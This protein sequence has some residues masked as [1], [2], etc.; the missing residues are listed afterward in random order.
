[1]N[2][3]LWGGTSHGAKS[4]GGGVEVPV[5]VRRSGSWSGSAVLVR[6]DRVDGVELVGDH[7]VEWSR[8]DRGRARSGGGPKGRSPGGGLGLGGGPRGF[9]TRFQGGS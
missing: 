8:G 7:G 3:D 9:R 5:V 6:G 1:M 2:P 4:T